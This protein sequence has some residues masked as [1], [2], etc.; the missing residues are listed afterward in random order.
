MGIG[1]LISEATSQGNYPLLAGS[2]VA[3]MV[4]VV[5]F[6]RLVWHRIYDW[7]DRRYRFER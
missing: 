3:M 6:N 7:V 1:A 5:G 2:L 4:V